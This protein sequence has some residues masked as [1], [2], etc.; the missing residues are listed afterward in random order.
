MNT[1]SIRILT[2]I[3]MTTFAS[4]A[5]AADRSP[6]IVFIFIDDM[7]YADP[8][9]FGNPMMKTPHI[10]R[11]A[12]EGVKLT[13]FYVNSPICSASRTAVTTGNYP[14]RWRIHS[15]L[16]SR[17]AN[18]A[19][20]MADQLDPKAPTTA[21]R[22][23]AAGYATA[24]FGKWHMG[25]G[26][27]VQDAPLPSAYGFDEHFVD[28]Q[29]MGP[30]ITDKKKTPKHLWT[31]TYADMSIDFM[32]R[33]KAKPFYLRF[34]PNDV[35]DRH[36]PA[37]GEAEKWAGSTKDETWQRFFAVLA[38]MDRQIGRLVDEID[39]LGLT[40]D[41][42]IVFTSDNGPTDWPVYYKNKDRVHPPGFTGPFFGRK[43]SLYEGGIRMPFIARWPGRIAPN[44]TNDVS[45]MAGIDL[46][47]IFRKIAGLPEDP[48]EKLDGV[49]MSA[50][51]FGKN[52]D[53]PKPVFWQYG[54]TFSHLR[55]GNKAYKSPSLAMRDGRWK[56]LMN[57]DGSELK[58]FDVVKDLGEKTNITELQSAVV[59]R[60]K[61]QLIAW[62]QQLGYPEMARAPVE[63]A[64]GAPLRQ[65]KEARATNARAQIKIKTVVPTSQNKPV[66]W[67]Y[68]LD[69][70]K[71]DW[72][73]TEFDDRAW[74]TGDA[75]FGREAPAASR[76]PNTVWTSKDIWLRREFEMPA[77]KFENLSL[78]LNYDE[79]AT[80]YINGVLAA[81]APGYNGAYE[82]VK[83]TPKAIAA[84]KPG[85]NRFAVHCR[86]AAGGQYIDLGLG[87]Y[88]SIKQP[89]K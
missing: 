21:K 71:E 4:V 55:P 39:K 20:R 70:P 66:S 76:K 42:L 88:E 47:V 19:R 38:D 28:H 64:P 2:F 24:H 77:G 61:A 22:L 44:T 43:W 57:P 35:H 89:S 56:L 75:P 49:D 32:R 18:R 54:G 59:G 12:T 8:S 58:L 40:K 86:N 17:S 16:A 10:D 25:G 9:C 52:I 36:S 53:R 3:L 80:I 45:V 23:K 13:S 11:L 72:F 65:K 7:G 31:K 46:P 27:D 5:T 60:M 67:R 51:L 33:N 82:R 6:N 26:R 78:I 84:I 73:N 68:T 74:K 87:V 41:T 69:T 79:N 34:F 50:A 29:G 15:Y 83:L 1:L 81:K 14:G 48:A 63:S 62:Y 30:K 37:P 85:K